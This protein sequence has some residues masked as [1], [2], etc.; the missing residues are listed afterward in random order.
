MDPRSRAG[1]MLRG[2]WRCPRTSGGMDKKARA[3]R[4]IGPGEKS[5]APW[6][7][8]AIREG[9]NIQRRGTCTGEIILCSSPA[10]AGPR[11]GPAPREL[12]TCIPVADAGIRTWAERLIE[13]M[14]HIIC[15]WRGR[16]VKI[17]SQR[18]ASST[19]LQEA[20]YF[21]DCICSHRFPPHAALNYGGQKPQ[22][23][24]GNVIVNSLYL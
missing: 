17:V 24:I 21:A 22:I 1:S 18:F 4:P 19:S 13:P 6:R 15:L 3:E 2:N 20:H 7:V 16:S 14:E 5:T 23:S 10:T 8:D 11:R 9:S 12:A